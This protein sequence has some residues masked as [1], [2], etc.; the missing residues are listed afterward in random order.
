MDI[1]IPIVDLTR[2]LRTGDDTETASEVARALS[3]Y[4]VLI[5]RDPRVNPSLPGQYRSM[6]ERFYRLPTEIKSKYIQE[7]LPD[8]RQIYETGWRPSY[9]EKPRRRTE[10]LHLIPDDAKP[11]EPPSADP[12]ERFM[13][14]VGLR[15][16]S[17]EFPEL[18]YLPR[19]TPTEIEEWPELS[20]AWGKTMGSAV[21]TIMELLA[22]GFGEPA[23]LFT[24]L[25]YQGTRKLAPTGLDLVKHGSPGT[26]AAGFHN[27]LS[28][29]TIHGRSNYPGLWAWTRGWK[30]FPVRLPD[31]GC[32][33][34]QG[35]RVLEHLTAGRTL[36][37]Y[38][39]VV[40]GLEAQDKIRFEIDQGSYP[41]RVSTTMFCNIRSNE[42]VEP[43][44]RFINEPAAAEYFKLREKR[45]TRDMRTLYEKIVKPVV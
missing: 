12:K 43:V 10:V 15:P 23:D 44:G 4:G 31:E 39:E 18:D 1:E 16:E 42:Y 29:I 32:L 22:I 33:L 45:G 34:I 5:I 11:H 37:G 14:P 8:G 6:M 41:V 24:R 40:I 35:G 20:D 9:T 2:Y 3:E 21:D 36:R 19:I 26:V 28:A 17:S 13:D 7:L 25:M 30:K 38:H 27:D